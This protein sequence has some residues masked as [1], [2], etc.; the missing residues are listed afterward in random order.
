[1]HLDNKASNLSFKCTRLSQWIF[2]Y[3]VSTDTNMKDIPCTPFYTTGFFSVIS[4][5]I[6]E[7]NVLCTSNYIENH[8]GRMKIV[9]FLYVN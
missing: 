8:P 6:M 9:H 1:M 7:S 4:L 5:I 2:C 3:N